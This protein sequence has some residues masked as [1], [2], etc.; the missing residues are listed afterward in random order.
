MKVLYLSLCLVTKAWSCE[1]A[2]VLILCISCGVFFFSTIFLFVL[3]TLIFRVRWHMERTRFVW[4]QTR[5]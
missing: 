3:N 2:H 5:K 1:P 4:M